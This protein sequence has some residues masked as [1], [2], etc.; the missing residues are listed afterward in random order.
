MCGAWKLQRHHNGKS[1]METVNFLN[2]WGN[3]FEFAYDTHRLSLYGNV[4]VWRRQWFAAKF[5]GRFDML[6]GNSE[7]N[8]D[9]PWRVSRR[10][11][12]PQMQNA[13]T[14]RRF[15]GREGKGRKKRKTK[16]IKFPV[17]FFLEKTRQGLISYIRDLALSR[18]I[19]INHTPH[20][21]L[22]YHRIFTFRKAQ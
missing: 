1:T 4:I 21:Q 15:R 5:P 7:I 14:L 6:S 2:Y 22:I 12:E 16:R 20:M 18:A 9:A 3:T 10:P 17:D 19:A 11:S 8:N 13:K